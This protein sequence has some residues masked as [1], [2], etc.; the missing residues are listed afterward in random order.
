MTSPLVPT[1][2]VTLSGKEYTLRLDLNA[3]S[4]F[5]TM[6][7]KS[8][9]RG[10]LQDIANLELSDVRALLW[11]MMVQD[12]ESLTMRDVGRLISLDDIAPLSETIQTMIINAM[13]DA[14]AAL[15]VDGQAEESP[16]TETSPSPVANGG[17]GSTPPPESTSA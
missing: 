12:N 3:L 1:G 7:G 14:A 17:L 9:L 10:G 8:V 15:E 16:L 6:T 2:S 4:D 11:A 13:P 5:E